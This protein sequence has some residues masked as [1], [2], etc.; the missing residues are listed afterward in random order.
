VETNGEGN[1]ERL[2][3]LIYESS[4]ASPGGTDDSLSRL[5]SLHP[6]PGGPE[7]PLQVH[8]AGLLTDYFNGGVA[9]FSGVPVDLGMLPPFSVRVLSRL[10]QVPYG[11]T[12]SYGWLAGQLDAPGAARAV[13]GALGRNPVPIVIPC[14]RIVA[15]GGKLGGF[16]RGCPRGKDI[17]AFLLRLE[18][19]PV[20]QEL[21]IR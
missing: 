20:S 1:A 21:P 6:T 10:R 17:K 18:G 5:Q 14:H 9:D 2:C 13:G 4:S 3:A 12:Q 16:M 19:R 8:L 11:E 7:T 15:V